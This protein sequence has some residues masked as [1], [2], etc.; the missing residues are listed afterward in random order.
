MFIPTTKQ[1]LEKLKWESCDIILISGDTYIDSPYFGIAV[2]G[3]LL[4]DAGFK[5]GIIAQPD[6]K[7]KNKEDIPDIGRLGEPKLFWGVTA[8]CMDSMVS[9]YTPTHKPR[10]SDDLTPGGINN[11]RP[12]RAVIVYCNEIRKYYKNTVPIV[13]GGMEASL[14]RLAHYDYWDNKIRR[15][16]LFDSKADF[17]IYGMAEKTILQ[18]AEILK[19][20]KGN[21]LD[22]IKGIRGI[23]YVSSDK[24]QKYIELPSY[25][26]VRNNMDKFIS[27]FK[28]FYKNNIPGISKGLV[29]KQDTRYLVQNPP[30]DVLT[31]RELDKIYGM[32]YEYDAHPFYKNMGIIK[33]LDTIKFSITSHRGCF[34]ECNFCA[35]SVHQGNVVISRSRESILSEVK[36]MTKLPGFKGIIYDVGGPTANM[37][38][39]G[40]KKFKNSHCLKRCCVFPTLCEQLH[41]S[42]LEQIKLMQDI[43]KIQGVKKVFIGSGIRYDL[44]INDK[45]YG[46]KYL[47][48]LIENHISGQLKI[49]PEHT[50][51]NI[52]KLMGKTGKQELI[53]FV[54]KY[55]EKNR[56]KGKK[57]FLTYYF[58]AAHPGC[59][60][61]DMLKLSEFI[62]KE[63]RFTPEQVQI[64][65]PTPGTWSS[66]MYY[67]E[68]NPWTG[69]KIFVEKNQKG[70]EEQKAIIKSRSNSSACA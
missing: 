29:Q 39:M 60:K 42:H 59:T 3:H 53:R 9:N 20:K 15:S 37:Y 10:R 48:E 18:F 1:E 22:E 58:I 45:E 6:L 40:C 23:C 46:D 14:R 25:D 13:I 68:K 65:T 49:A 8:G 52:L 2:I 21:Y 63:L 38:A 54:K 41:N 5:V 36:K 27:F 67:T 55:F 44:L 51:D 28:V 61:K 66:V 11:K 69:E 4:I 64:F 34:G 70:K 47:D 16:I 32:D 17:L 7:Q 56:K 12:D 19:E 26:E 62:K 43:R 33:A 35:I 31:S 57:Q 30:Q 50:Q 24:P